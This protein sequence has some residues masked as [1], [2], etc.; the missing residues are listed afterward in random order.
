[1]AQ[2]GLPR[3]EEAGIVMRRRREGQEG[4]GGM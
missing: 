2:Q 4:D 3:G 1:M